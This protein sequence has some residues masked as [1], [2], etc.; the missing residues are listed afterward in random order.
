M[1]SVASSCD[2]YA[3][4]DYNNG[5]DATS[6]TAATQVQPPSPADDAVADLKRKY[7]LLLAA[8]QAPIAA[9][10]AT[11]I[12]PKK[13]KSSTA[14]RTY[15]NFLRYV[16]ILQGVLFCFVSSRT[17]QSVSPKCTIIRRIN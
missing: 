7:E 13:V 9:P 12:N 6:Y 8:H 10:V 3:S 5:T 4:I 16:A 14:C 15:G 1:Q 11:A 2:Y 17:V